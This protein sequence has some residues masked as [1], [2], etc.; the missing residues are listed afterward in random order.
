MKIEIYGAEWCKPCRNSKQ[1][2]EDKKLD[3]TFY[4]ISAEPE[5]L[6]KVTEYLGKE[7]RT[8]PQIFIDGKHIGGSVEFHAMFKEE[9]T[10]G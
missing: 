2:C 9:H 3:Y 10:N 7:P 8:I 1:L 6:K 5:A 4:D